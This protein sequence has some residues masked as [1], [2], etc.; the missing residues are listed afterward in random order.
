KSARSL[1][2]YGL[3]KLDLQFFNSVKKVFDELAKLVEEINKL[4]KEI[5]TINEVKDLNRLSTLDLQSLKIGK[6]VNEIAGLEGIIDAE[7]EEQEAERLRVEQ[8]TNQLLND[9]EEE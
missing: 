7:R 3:F 8:E 2:T 6:K 5:N 9:T 1:P 4:N